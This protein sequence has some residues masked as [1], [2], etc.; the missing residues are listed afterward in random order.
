MNQGK[1]KGIIRACP[2]GC[3]KCQLGVDL[4]GKTVK[5][6]FRDDLTKEV[7]GQRVTGRA[8]YV[9]ELKGTL[10]VKKGGGG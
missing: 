6:V 8:E 4:E 2:C 3:G 10:L 7:F 1:L 9:F 5:Q